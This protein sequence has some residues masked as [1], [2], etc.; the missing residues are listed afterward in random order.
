M[1]LDPAVS[2]TPHPPAQDW[3]VD[4]SQTTLERMGSPPE[5]GLGV[6]R[7]LGGDEA[8]APKPGEMT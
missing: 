1:E 6:E 5:H 2:R 7:S 4:I 8:L 3:V